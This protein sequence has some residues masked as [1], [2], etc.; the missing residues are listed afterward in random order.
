MQNSFTTTALSLGLLFAV[1]LCLATKGMLNENTIRMNGDM[2]RHLMNGALILD[3]LRNLPVTDP[4]WYLSHYYASYPAISLGF[5]PPLLPLAEAPFFA[6]FG[7]SIFSGRV[8]MIVFLLIGVIAW[9]KLISLVYD[10][11][12]AFLSSLLMVTNPYLIDQSRMVMTD[13]PALAMV[14]LTTYLLVLFCA[15]CRRAYGGGFL[16]AFLFSILARPQTLFMVPVYL[17]YLAMKRRG[18]P[19]LP[20]LVSPPVVLTG[21]CIAAVAAAFIR[22]GTHNVQWLTHGSALSHITSHNLLYPLICLGKYHVGMPVLAVALVSLTSGWF[23]KDERLTLFLAWLVCTYLQAVYLGPSE[24][25]Y[26]FYWLPPLCLLVALTAGANSNRI[27]TAAIMI[28]LLLSGQQFRSAMA[29]DPPVTGGYLEAA[30]Y[31]TG[32]LAGSTVL[33]CS[34][35]DT[36]YLCFFARSLAPRRTTLILRADKILATASFNRIVNEKISTKE[37]LYATLKKLGITHV[38]MDGREFNSRSLTL[39]KN[40]VFSDKFRLVQSIRRHSAGSSA[41]SDITIHEF[42]GHTP[43]EQGARLCMAL[44]LVSHTINVS[45]DD[46]RAFRP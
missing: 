5:H 29:M 15:N 32:E 6:L 4:L 35:R 13:V 42:T 38:V 43:P 18:Q 28:I 46:L 21:V 7:V 8:V 30:R 31:V 24:A 17:L 45:L 2:P 10:Q 33:Y 34:S 40:E 14:I 44:P 12:T 22:L 25:R 27:R 19:L 16:L 39:L 9:F 26:S 37:E 41:G 1:I 3:L 11:K 23:K 20:L 36:G